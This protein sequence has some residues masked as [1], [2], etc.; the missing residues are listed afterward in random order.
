MELKRFL[1][2]VVFFTIIALLYVHQQVLIYQTGERLKESHRQY[3]KL[4]D[5]NKALVYNVLNL[6][7]P[8]S[9]EKRLQN[10]KIVLCMPREWEALRTNKTK[11]TFVANTK[12]RTGILARLIG[13]DRVAE[14]SGL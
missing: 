14:A 13:T 9:L 7:S 12:N 6:K 2:I 1:A 11:N 5:H 8:S 4:V 3:L 10:Q